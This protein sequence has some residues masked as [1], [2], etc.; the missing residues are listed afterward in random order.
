MNAFLIGEKVV[1]RSSRVG[2]PTFL[3]LLRTTPPEKAYSLI[4]TA[5]GHV[6]LALS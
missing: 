6:L 5:R 2:S 3:A 1:L 4:K